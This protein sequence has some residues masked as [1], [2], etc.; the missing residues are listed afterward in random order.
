MSH[1]DNR[2]LIC[3]KVDYEDQWEPEE[4]DLGEFLCETG[5]NRCPASSHCVDD[6]DDSE[7]VVYRCECRNVTVEGIDLIPMTPTVGLHYECKYTLPDLDSNVEV[8]VFT[9][10]GQPA[11]YHQTG[12]MHWSAAMKYCAGLRM[13]L[14]LC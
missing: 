11:V 13:H 5:L 9:Y 1:R 7:Y 10:D 14:P 2:G 12:E 3:I 6:P 4:F 8:N